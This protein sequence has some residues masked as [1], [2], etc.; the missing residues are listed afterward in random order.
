M[1]LICLGSSAQKQIELK[2]RHPMITTFFMGSLLHKQ[3]L[4][5]NTACLHLAEIRSIL[6]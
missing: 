5:S 6:S 4:H 3:E 1:P 2:P